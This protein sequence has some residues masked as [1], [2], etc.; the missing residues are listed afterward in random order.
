[1]YNIYIRQQKMSFYCTILIK[2]HIRVKCVV[3]NRENITT[4]INK[5][6]DKHH[7]ITNHFRSIDFRCPLT[8]RKCLTLNHYKCE[9][10]CDK[11]NSERL[12]HTHEVIFIYN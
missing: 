4:H 6:L 12:V 9:Q 11:Y 7:S 1:M 5:P 10:V 2:L 8:R 3:K